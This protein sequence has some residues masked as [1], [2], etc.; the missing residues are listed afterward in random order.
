LTYLYEGEGT[1][2]P[3]D[4]TFIPLS[5]GYLRRILLEILGREEYEDI[6]RYH[7]PREAAQERRAKDADGEPPKAQVR[8]SD[9]RLAILGALPDGSTHSYLRLPPGGHQFALRRSYERGG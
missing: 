8:I 2:P 1:L 6:E 5:H 9:L 3:V 4:H 7:G